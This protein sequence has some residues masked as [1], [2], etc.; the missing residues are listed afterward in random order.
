MTK[1][2]RQDTRKGRFTNGDPVPLPDVPYMNG[3][4]L[5]GIFPSPVTIKIK[6]RQLPNDYFFV[7]LFVVSERIKRLLEEFNVIAEYFPLQIEYRGAPYTER[8]FYFA[9]II[10]HVDCFDFSNSVYTLHERD[11]NS[12]S[13]I[14]TLAIDESKTAGHHLFQVARVSDLIICASESLAKRIEAADVT[15]VVFVPVDMWKRY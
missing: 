5:T 13:R 7:G 12:V 8:E 14:E 2:W 4:P 6:T 15:G 10:D 3:V 1:L 11:S 9:N